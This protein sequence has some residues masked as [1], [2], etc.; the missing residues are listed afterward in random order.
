MARS[1]DE[2]LKSPPLFAA[3]LD[4]KEPGELGLFID[5]GQVSMLK[6]LMWSEGFLDQRRM[7]GAFRMLRS[8]DIVWPRIVRKYLL[9]ERAPMSDLMAWN[10]DATRLALR[11]EY[12]RRLYLNNDF[13]QGR[14]KA[15]GQPVHVEDIRVPVFAVGTV[16]DHVAPWRSVFRLTHLLDTEVDF[17]LTPGGHN[18]GVL[19][20]PG[21]RARSY[22]HLRQAGQP[23]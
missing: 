21:H 20:E 18:A 13:A 10:A 2:R 6:D 16:T 22:K 19:S 23:R 12:L 15:D 3:Q 8:Q 11:S 4:F 5:E 17:V 14:W 1:G 7:A 9:G